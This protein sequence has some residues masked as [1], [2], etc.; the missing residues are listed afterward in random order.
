MKEIDAPTLSE[1]KYRDF[2]N[3]YQSICVKL[4]KHGYQIIE[5]EMSE[6]HFIDECN[7]NEWTFTE[8]GVMFNK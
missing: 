8:E 3:I 7:A 2:E 6:A 1:A 5:D 4:V